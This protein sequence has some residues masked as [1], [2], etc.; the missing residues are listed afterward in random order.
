MKKLGKILGLVGAAG[1]S[2][3]LSNALGAPSGQW[4]GAGPDPDGDSNPAT[5][6]RLL[7]RIGDAAEAA[8]DP[9]FRVITFE[10]PPGGHGDVI[11]K[12]YQEKYGVTFSRG[13][14][15]QICEGQR[16][17]QYNSECTYLRAPSGDYAAVYRDD[18]GRPLR[19][20]FE[21]AVCAASLAIYPTG[22][23][24]GEEYIIT[25]QPYAGDDHPLKKVTVPF[26]W[27]HDTFRWRMMAGAYFT[28]LRATRVDVSIE[29]RRKKSKNKIV[30]FLIDDVASIEDSPSTPADECANWLAENA[31]AA[32]P[33][34]S[35][36]KPSNE[37]PE[38][39][40]S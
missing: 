6:T 29:S 20:R 25:L 7:V 1:A 10:A 27:T 15:R 31:G 8:L 18:W 22:G 3:T 17:F 5:N 2:F 32:K 12:Q 28:D 30:R 36:A 13:L 40:G 24:E 11:R 38:V 33:V 16:Y 35:S 14:K 19:I 23:K 39:S 37:I 9:P 21:R 34:A 26:K 4:N